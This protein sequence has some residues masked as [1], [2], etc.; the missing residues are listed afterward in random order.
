MAGTRGAG[1]LGEEAAEAALRKERYRILERNYRTPVGEIDLVARQGRCLCFVEV[2]RRSSTSYGHPAEAVTDEK[3]RRIARAA[4]WY[5]AARGA[6]RKPEG[7]PRPPD[8]WP[9]RGWQGECRF[10]VVSVLDSAG[11]GPPRIEI[12]ADAFGG[13]YAPRKRR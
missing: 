3:K 2:K 7:A 6:R 5:L 10:D 9:F 4:E 8:P 11:G 13:P 12:I 1:S